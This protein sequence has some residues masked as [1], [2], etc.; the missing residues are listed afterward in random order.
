VSGSFQCTLVTPQKQ[1][2]DEAVTYASFPAHD[3][4]VGIAPSRAP[5][6]AELGHGSLR[7]DFADGGTRWLFIGGGFAQMKDN[8]LSIVAD[9]ATPAEEIVQ[10]KAQADLDAALAL[11]GTG[12]EVV[13][14]KARAVARARAMLDIHQKHG[15][16]V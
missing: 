3:G 1:V 15:N 14:R 4:Q 6:L 16:Q 9:E 10:S 5:L 12:N 7:L 13:E 11:S 2:L 8:K